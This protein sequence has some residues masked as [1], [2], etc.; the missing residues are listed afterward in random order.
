M[1]KG[2][3]VV[4]IIVLIIGVGL[5]PAS[6]G[7]DKQID[8]RM[9]TAIIIGFTQTRSEF[10][11]EAELY[12]I[13]EI[14][15][16]AMVGLKDYQTNFMPR[17]VNGS[18]SAQ[19]L[20]AIIND[21]ASS[22]G[23][24]NA[25]DLFFND[26]SWTVSTSGN[27]DIEGIS[28]Y[29][30]MG[31]LTYS[32]DSQTSI[33]NFLTGSGSG[34]NVFNYI[35]DIEDI[36]EEIEQYTNGTG[37][38]NE[39]ILSGSVLYVAAGTDGL[40]ALNV[41][42]LENVTQIDHYDTGTGEAHD[43][44]RSGDLVYVAAGSDGLQILNISNPANI[45]YVN[46]YIN[47][48]GDT[49]GIIKSGDLAY[50]ADGTDGLRIL[51]I[52]D[53]TNISQVV[54]YVN[55]TAE[56]NKIALSGSFAYVADGADGLEILDI[57]VP[58]NVTRVGHFDD[59]GVA[60]DL[61]IADPYLYLADGS[62]GFE[63]IDISNKSNPIQIGQYDDGGEAN[64]L[65]ISGSLAFVADGSDG[66]EIISISNKTN[67]VQ[68]GLDFNDGGEANGFRLQGSVAFIADGSDGLEIYDMTYPR[69]QADLLETYD[70]S[71]DQILYVSEYL[72]DHLIPLVPTLAGLP[73]EVNSTNAEKLFLM[74]WT[75]ATFISGTYPVKFQGIINVFNWEFDR[76]DLDISLAEAEKIWNVSDSN[77]PF[78]E[79]QIR[80]W[81][82]ATYNPTYFDLVKNG[83]SLDE[84]VS[85]GLLDY[86]F[87]TTLYVDVINRIYPHIRTQTVGSR[88]QD[89]IYL[90]WANSYIRPEGLGSID[91]FYTGFEVTSPP[92]E[93]GMNLTQ[94]ASIWN[95]N[96]E[97]S[98]RSL[99]GVPKWFE[100]ARLPEAQRMSVAAGY[101][102]TD[103]FDLDATQINF[104]CDW[105]YGSDGSDGYRNVS[106]YISQDYYGLPLHPYVLQAQMKI[107]TYI[108]A[109]IIGIV[110][111]VII[112]KSLRKE[113]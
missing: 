86:L 61:W 55:G 24:E 2:K 81:I 97:N 67:P 112:V 31:N 109:G 95:S 25:T 52:T 85:A 87:N 99:V 105:L 50:I 75:N 101:N 64:G 91:P 13:Q 98:L 19:S 39:I 113:R 93:L 57:S 78:N 71:W 103:E 4:G 36:P 18:V 83:W 8:N 22:I 37:S 100:L 110:G 58:E 23:L 40:R 28:E 94:L 17:L 7:M 84:S 76:P 108:G 82:R 90:Q 107:G 26:P 48:T 80:T 11:S 12:A 89:L 20:N 42:D 88:A 72:T 41:S 106:T 35:N 29:I 6:I 10:I 47:G 63:V 32:A 14:I 77:S 21:L 102:I 62:D 92:D 38:F 46:S 60:N 68:L 16:D 79:T 49:F 43:L 96:S 1:G 5:I 111:L 30:G 69:L 53:P 70:A 15:P 54:Q 56:A 51:N 45:T 74:Q 3:L 59:G 33:Y 34:S 73:F 66:F 65:W 27:Y 44:T 9:D 104:I